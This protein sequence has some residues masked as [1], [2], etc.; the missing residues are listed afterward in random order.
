[1]SSSDIWQQ[2]SVCKKPILHGATYYKC[3]VSSCNRKSFRLYF[4]TPGCWDAHNPG[5]NHRNPGYTEEQAPR[6]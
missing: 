1:M 2:C 6:R 4:C 3:A 5:Q